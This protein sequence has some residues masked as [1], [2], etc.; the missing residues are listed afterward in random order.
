M[1]NRI[2]CL[3]LVISFGFAGNSSSLA[4]Y[5]QDFCQESLKPNDCLNACINIY[6]YGFSQASSGA[7]MA[8]SSEM[9]AALWFG[10]GVVITSAAVCC[11]IFPSSIANG[12]TNQVGHISRAYTY[13]R[14]IANKCRLLGKK[15]F[16]G[17]ALVNKLYG[18]NIMTI[19]ASL[20]END[21]TKINLIRQSQE[22]LEENYFLLASL[23]MEKALGL[24]PCP[25]SPE[26]LLGDTTCYFP[27]TEQV[28]FGEDDSGWTKNFIL[29][30]MKRL[31]TWLACYNL[32]ALTQAEKEAVK[33]SM[34]E[35]INN[36]CK[37]INQH[38]FV[39][40]SQND[41]RI[42]QLWLTARMRF[43]WDQIADSQKA[44]VLSNDS[45]ISAD[46]TELP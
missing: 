27:Q 39:G 3:V 2:F 24:E 29:P 25:Q 15:G 21:K 34:F 8:L 40:S 33:N 43:V 6:E 16:S 11:G 35:E 45:E 14:G 26:I 41:E 23:F 32:N 17:V 36:I 4:T 19:L 13:A 46:G 5:C 37:K 10:A 20:D 28:C 9:Q 38:G 42:L 22:S 18:D 1:K 30:D 7:S 31:I 12:L 44:N